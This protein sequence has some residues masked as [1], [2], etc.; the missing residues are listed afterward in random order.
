MTKYPK[1][2]TPAFSHAQEFKA[3]FGLENHGL[4]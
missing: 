1:F 3:D 2:N 4:K